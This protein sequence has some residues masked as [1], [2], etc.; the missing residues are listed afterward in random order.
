MYVV[1][2]Y[3]VW[4][5][6]WCVCVYTCSVCGVACSVCG[7]VVGP[8]VGTSVLHRLSYTVKCP[9]SAQQRR[10]SGGTA[11]HLRESHFNKST[12][13]KFDEQ[14]EMREHRYLINVVSISRKTWLQCFEGFMGQGGSF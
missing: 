7:V 13:G 1:C 11:L 8:P 2:V 12:G 9:R 4:L 14:R 5:C 3:V 10:C 6:V